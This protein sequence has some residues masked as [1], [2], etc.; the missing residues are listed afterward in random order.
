MT[1]SRSL[2]MNF[3]PF[4][5]LALSQLKQPASD[6]D[7]G[8]TWQPTAG[9]SIWMT[10]REA[11]HLGIC[12]GFTCELCVQSE[13]KRC[14]CTFCFAWALNDI[15]QSLFF[16]QKPA[17]SVLHS[18]VSAS[19]KCLWLLGYVLDWWYGCTSFD[20]WWYYYCRCNDL[21]FDSW[22]YEQSYGSAHKTVVAKLHSLDSWDV[23]Q[24][25]SWSIWT[26]TPLRQSFNSDCDVWARWTDQ[27]IHD[28]MKINENHGMILAS[29]LLISMHRAC[30]LSSLVRHFNE[31]KQV[32]HR[33][34]LSQPLRGPK[35]LT[36]TLV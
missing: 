29:E 7:N 10:S 12:H 13:G 3:E 17:A 28:F 4:S 16:L 2:E 23:G 27:N 19:M 8:K 11:A 1:H 20:H 18:S 6:G 24:T 31:D 26:R 21:S 34:V 22:R 36:W 35:V 25:S 33:E 14:E 5:C 30:P 15:F 32:L 9:S